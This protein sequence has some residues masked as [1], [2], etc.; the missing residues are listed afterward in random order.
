VVKA[1][2]ASIRTSEEFIGKLS[3][4]VRRDLD[5]AVFAAD[6]SVFTP[7]E[8]A[9]VRPQ[10]NGGDARYKF[11]N[12]FQQHSGCLHFHL[13]MTC[14]CAQTRHRMTFSCSCSSGSR[15]WRAEG[16]IEPRIAR[17]FTGFALNKQAEWCRVARSTS[18][19]GDHWCRHRPIVA[20]ALLR[21]SPLRSD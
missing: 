17:S 19:T 10:E 20:K 4:T 7:P 16:P 15:T 6:Q 21:E 8:A 5:C 9:S 2:V 18:I 13:T 3:C 14:V 1:A 12:R 11:T